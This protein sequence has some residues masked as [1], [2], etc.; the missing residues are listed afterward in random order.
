MKSV[1]L[2]IDSLA[3]GGA[4]WQIVG[5]AFLLKERGYDVQVLTYYD[6]PFYASFLEKHAVP[7]QVI[8]NAVSPLKRIWNVR[9]VLKHRHP[10]TVISYLDTPNMLACLAKMS[11]LRFQLIVSE[12][13]TTQ[14]LSIKKH[15]LFWLYHYADAI[16][17]NSVTQTEFIYYHFPTLAQKVK[18][19]TNFVDL[20]AFKPSDMQKEFH[21]LR[22]IGVGRMEPQKNISRLIE[23]VE[24]VRQQGITVVFDWYGRKTSYTEKYQAKI[25]QCGLQDVFILHDA[26]YDIMTKYQEADLF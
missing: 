7:Y 23:A 14:Q 10:N 3:Q 5:L 9:K 18:T 4:Q 13:N 16:V 2:L 19:I 26:T 17:P 20:D 25:Q 8:D 24:E 12:R 22:M 1:V 15:I 21:P 11:G 6:I